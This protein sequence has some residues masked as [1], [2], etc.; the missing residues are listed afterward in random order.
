MKSTLDN[1]VDHHPYPFSYNVVMCIIFYDAIG[2][3]YLQVSYN[4]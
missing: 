2:I 3:E 1:D 4:V